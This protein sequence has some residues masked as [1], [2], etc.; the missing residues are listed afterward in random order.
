MQLANMHPL[1]RHLRQQGMIVTAWIQSRNLPVQ[2][3]K[4][5]IYSGIYHAETIDKLKD[6]GLY[7]LLTYKVRDKLERIENKRGDNGRN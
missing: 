1:N 2:Q 3:A 5:C 4:N 6:E 7:H